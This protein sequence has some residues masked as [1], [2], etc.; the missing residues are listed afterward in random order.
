MTVL[1][2][3]L[4]F[5]LLGY[6]GGLISS[7]DT[8]VYENSNPVAEKKSAQ[9][10]PINNLRDFNNALVEI[11]SATTPA[12]VTVRTEQTVR[13]QSRTPQDFFREFFGDP[14]GNGGNEGQQREYRQQ[15][16][17]SGV[18]VSED[19]YILTN[20]H[21]VASADTIYVGLENGDELTAEIVGTDPDSDIAVLR[22]DAQ[23]LPFM[24]FGNS[25]ELKTGEM[26]LAV[27]SPLNP[28]LAHSVSQ[29]IVSSTGRSLGLMTFE[30][31]IQTDAAI[32]RGNSGGPL[33][34]MDGNIIGIN[35]AIASQSGG[36][37]GIGFAIPS[38]I[39]SSIMESIIEHGSVI[40]GFIGIS[41]EPVSENIA[42]AF[43]LERTRGILVNDIVP[44]S[45]AEEA[46]MQSGDVII[47]VNGETIREP[48]EFQFEIAN[49][50][51]GDEVSLTIIRNGEEE[52]VDITLTQ[53]PQ[54]DEMAADD[55]GSVEDITGFA[56]RNL[57]DEIT[58]QLRI[59]PNVEGVVVESIDQNSQAYRNN[60][61]QGDV[62]IAVNQNPVIS[63]SEF[64]SIVSAGASRD[65]ILLQVIRQNQRF[66]V[67]FEP[68]T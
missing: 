24:T 12:V 16:M 5:F 66:F 67:A 29:G 9:E 45:P 53:R 25:D 37:Q 60:L 48:R 4:L 26:V 43:G 35:T 58:E 49:M 1:S 7:N 8:Y 41:F 19:G 34:N 32:N 39:A 61:R 14:R 3:V 36:F 57:S 6:P 52:S 38:N 28:G 65:V 22:V 15:G 2:V 56:V 46:G 51:P 30:N 10:R 13:M 50:K 47:E 62:I 40:R 20:N 18:I 21:V 23:N 33:V 17:G 54:D 44:D 63:V 55:G 31:F 27:G 68:R 11:A 59:P 42:R 64:N